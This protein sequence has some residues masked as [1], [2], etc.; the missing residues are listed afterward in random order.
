M[1]R[2]HSGIEPRCS[3]RATMT[4]M[5]HGG[6]GGHVACP[7]SAN[8]WAS[9]PSR[10]VPDVSRTIATSGRGSRIPELPRGRTGTPARTE[11]DSASVTDDTSIAPHLPVPC[12]RVAP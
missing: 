6:D 3:I 4:R 5:Q 12:P 9:I 8:A 11:M 2:A 7:Y 10:L 1:A